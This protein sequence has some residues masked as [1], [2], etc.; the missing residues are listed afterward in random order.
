MLV[1]STTSFFDS[2]EGN[3]VVTSGKATLNGL[4]GATNDIK[5]AVEASQKTWE[6]VSKTTADSTDQSVENIIRACRACGES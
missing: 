6:S 5:N 3:E 1:S 4:T 2:K